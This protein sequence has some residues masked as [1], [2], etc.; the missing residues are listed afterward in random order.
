MEILCLIINI[1]IYAGYTA[2]VLLAGSGTAAVI[3]ER[4]RLRYRLHVKRYS[5]IPSLDQAAA[6]L[7]PLCALLFF[8]S[9]F[10]AWRSFVPAA[11]L[12]ISVLLASIPMLLH[13]AR[14]GMDRRRAGKEGISLVSE[15]CR[16][17]RIKH[18]NIYEAMEA[19]IASGKSFPVCS[20]HL[21]L[22]LM[23][24]RD[25]GSREAV[26][27]ACRRFSSVVGTLWG[28][29]LSGCVQTAVLSGADV[30]EALSDIEAQLSSA[31]KLLEERKRLNSEAV[32]MTVFL[33][34]LLYAGTMIIA[35]LSLK[36]ELGDILKNQFA[37]PEGL[38]LFVLSVFLF[39]L[40]II[41]LQAVEG[42]G[43]DI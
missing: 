1:V 7:L 42:G 17:Y 12:L 20:R 4:L 38:M 34:P 22:L 33:V 40:D 5:G 11:A 19:A 39:L 3:K 14:R 9:L 18:S 16:Q 24:L 15:L 13:F 36:M 10:A 41:I 6:R 31:Q 43:A 30:S 35:A 28:S 27:S 25:A 8:V 37:S 23:R 21:S 29:M 26:I 2:G 32:R